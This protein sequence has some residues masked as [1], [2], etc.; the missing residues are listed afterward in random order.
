MLAVP[1]SFA[2]LSRLATEVTS[3]KPATGTTTYEAGKDY[4]FERGMLFI[5]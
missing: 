4:R 5:R 1:G 3:V 2:P